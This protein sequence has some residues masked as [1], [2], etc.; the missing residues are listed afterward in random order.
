MGWGPGQGVWKSYCDQAGSRASFL[1]ISLACLENCF[2]GFQPPALCGSPAGCR[3]QVVGGGQAEDTAGPTTNLPSALARPRICSCCK[4]GPG[5]RCMC[6]HSV[7]FYFQIGCACAQ[8]CGCLWMY[9]WGYLVLKA[10][11]VPSSLPPFGPAEAPPSVFRAETAVGI[12]QPFLIGGP[13]FPQAWRLHSHGSVCL[14][15]YP[16]MSLSMGLL[17][18]G[19][20]RCSPGGTKCC[21]ATGLAPGGLVPELSGYRLSPRAGGCRAQ[22]AGN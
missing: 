20:E 1:F 2:V 8:V 22:Q 11:H 9:G 4:F 18:A 14:P 12:C 21:P 19:S 10:G 13:W 3:G 5:M 6:G 7:L 16:S 17:C 15:L